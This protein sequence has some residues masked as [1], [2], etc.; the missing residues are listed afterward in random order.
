MR[1][2]RACWVVGLVLVVGCSQNGGSASPG[3]DSTQVSNRTEVENQIAERLLATRARLDSL[4][5][6]AAVLGAKL[7]TTM[8]RRIAAVE[9]EKDSAGARLEYLQ[10]VSE[11]DWRNARTEVAV[12]LDSLDTRIDRLRQNLHRGG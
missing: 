4:R 10:Q 8:T 11:E 12:M 9:A 3:S 1:S 2:L 7:D 6:E 5:A